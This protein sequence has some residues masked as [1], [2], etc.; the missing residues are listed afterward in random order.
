VGQ[1]GFLTNTVIVSDD[2]GQFDVGQHALCWVTANASFTSS[3]PSPTNTAWPR[4]TSA[5]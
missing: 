1:H 3:T 4:A 2:A 5:T